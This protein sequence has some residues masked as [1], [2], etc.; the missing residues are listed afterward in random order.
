MRNPFAS[1][2]PFMSLWRSSANKVMI[3]ARGKAAAELKRSVGT[4][5]TEA[6]SQVVD[7]GAASRTHGQRPGTSRYDRLGD[8]ARYATHRPPTSRTP[9]SSALP[10]A[11]VS[12]STR[13]ELLFA[14]CWPPNGGWLGPTISARCAWPPLFRACCPYCLFEF[15]TGARSAAP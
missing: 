3:S 10:S 11:C 12:R 1:K 9:A 14:R 15:K 5:Q 4:A 2:N 6:A 7:F 13:A 8:A